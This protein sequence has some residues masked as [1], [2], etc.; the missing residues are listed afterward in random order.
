MLFLA[1]N[2]I[3]TLSQPLFNQTMCHIYLHYH[4]C[5]PNKP[6]IQRTQPFVMG[7]SGRFLSRNSTPL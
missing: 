6:E 3:P 7:N 5:F 1:A 2:Y 4:P